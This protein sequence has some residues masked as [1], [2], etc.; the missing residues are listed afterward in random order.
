MR[1]SGRRHRSPFAFAPSFWNSWS[2]PMATV[3]NVGLSFVFTASNKLKTSFGSAS[4]DSMI[5]TGLPSFTF[6]HTKSLLGDL[7]RSSAIE[8]VGTARRHQVK[9]QRRKWNYIISEDTPSDIHC[10]VC[11]AVFGVSVRVQCRFTSLKWCISMS[12]KWCY[13]QCMPRKLELESA[14]RVKRSTCK[15]LSLPRTNQ[16]TSPRS[17]LANHFFWPSAEWTANT[18]HC[19]NGKAHDQKFA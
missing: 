11:D 16:A 6:T 7:L 17:F 4:W 14:S 9:H 12:L 3:S 15:K 19:Q 8:F 18:W 5:L 10:F 13:K 1:R 2:L